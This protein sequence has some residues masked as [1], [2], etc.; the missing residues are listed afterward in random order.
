[1]AWIG[2]G[3]T[4]EKVFATRLTS[5]GARAPGWPADGFK[6][7]AARGGQDAPGIVPDGAGGAIIVWLD[8]GAPLGQVY[9]QRITA[10]GAIASRWPSD[11]LL[12]CASSCEPALTRYPLTEL[13]TQAYTS[14][15]SDGAGGMFV[16]W[17]DTRTD[18]G[19]VYVQHVL[20]D[21]SLAAGW[22]ANGL[23]VCRA[24][25]VQQSPALAADGLGGAIVSWQDNRA[26]GEWT[27]YAQRVTS[28][29]HP[30]WA[31]DGIP[32]CTAPRDH[33][34]PRPV[35]DGSGG[36]IIAWQDARCPGQAVFA[37]QVGADGTLPTGPAIPLASAALLGASADQGVVRVDWNVTL[38]QGVIATIYSWAAGG[39]WH[40]VGSMAP[41]PSGRVSFSDAN[42]LGGCLHGYGIGLSSCSDGRSIM[43]TTVVSVPAGAGFPSLA[44]TRQSADPI[45]GGLQLGW[46][47]ARGAGLTASIFRRTDCSSPS[48]IATATAEDSGFVTHFDPGLYQ[49]QREYYRL[50]VHACDA[51]FDLGEASVVVPTSNEYLDMQAEVI[52][53]VVDSTSAFLVWKV[54]RGSPESARLYRRV[55]GGEWVALGY[56]NYERVGEYAFRDPGLIPG[57]HYDFRVGLRN[58][59]VEYFTDVLSIDTPRGPGPGSI[60]SPPGILGLRGAVPNP[61]EERLDVSF[62]LVGSGRATLEVFDVRGRVVVRRDVS[63]LGPGE[64]SLSLS[65][66]GR[67]RPGVYVIRLTEGDRQLTRRASIVH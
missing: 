43:A 67:L 38:P 41:D 23:A 32:I 45:N 17:R 62:S 36:A 3:G 63:S 7:C 39:T 53:T 42:A 25:W 29:G 12:L 28:D 66:A 52:S 8:G 34:T 58:C 31:A 4:S 5:A 48:L 59:A 16:A 44:L 1:V 50:V 30:A 49:G 65:D 47:I 14:P 11:G 35:G 10:D 6:V 61:G 57:S 13:Y 18:G 40:V 54:V 22:P 27:V 24:P 56:G 20:P 26:L 60:P 51:D 55:P 19:D 15:V 21:A 64:H 46:T 33:V 2:W 9:A 37:S